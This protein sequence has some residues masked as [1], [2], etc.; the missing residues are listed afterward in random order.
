MKTVK[1]IFNQRV[2]WKRIVTAV[3]LVL[4]ILVVVLFSSCSKIGISVQSPSPAKAQGECVVLIHGMA[5]TLHSMDA[6][7]EYLTDAGYYTVSLGYPSTQKT[8]EDIAADHF[9]LAVEQCQEFH[10][11]AI[12]FVTH[13]LGGIILRTV[14]KEKKPENM[15][16]VVMLS[17]P[18]K[19]SVAADRLKDWWFYKWLNGPAGQQLT[20]DED[21]SPNRLGPVD[22]PVGIIT[23]DRYFFF[24]FW[25]SSM[26]PGRDD[27]K[28]SVANARLDGMDDFLVVHETHPFIMDAEYV[29]DETLHFLQHGK[30]KHQKKALAAVSGLNW[31]SFSSD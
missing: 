28:V 25:L 27:G 15:G 1:K 23:G 4:N 11:S 24:D 6:M 10:P 12:H 19:G 21:S 3:V 2:G 30:F 16:R 31:F 17:P 8:I 29:H 13:S 22:Y 26:I 9:Q 7:Q 20:T 14:L 18:N 5:R